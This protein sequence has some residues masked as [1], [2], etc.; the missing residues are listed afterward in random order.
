VAGSDQSVNLGGMLTNIGE[1]VGSMA[2]PYK[3][4]M[5]AATKPRGDMN[6]PQHLMNLA[7]WASSNGDSA[8]AGAYMQ[9][10]NRLA[11]TAKADAKQLRKEQGATAMGNISVAMQQ[12]LKDGGPNAE[13]RMQALQEAA[14]VQAAKYGMDG[15]AASNMGNEARS[16]HTQL[17]R[18]ENAQRTE[19]RAL[20]DREVLDGLEAAAAESPEKLAAMVKR[21]TA[22][23]NGSIVRQFETARIQYEETV[24]Q[25]EENEAKRGPLSEEELAKAKEFNISVEGAPTSSVRASIKQVE[26]AKASQS[27]KSAKAKTIGLTTVKSLLPTILDQMGS[28]NFILDSGVDDWI[29]D[30]VDD[31]AV[32]EALAAYVEAQGT[33]EGANVLEGVR[34]AVE[35]YILATQGS[36][37]IFDS[38]SDQIR[39]ERAA[40]GGKTTVGDVTIEVIED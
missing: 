29:E 26:V 16:A 32:M 13:A 20:A 4:V 37:A 1:T 14:Q 18:Q 8:A 25:A 24:A 10:A 31:P 39:E 19:E 9:Q 6:D 7:Q 27:L 2:D 38:A 5:Q 17:I 23:G 28:G 21:E 22:K 33:P 40:A 35:D 34:T 36:G 11:D 3:N 30:A 12:V 15:V